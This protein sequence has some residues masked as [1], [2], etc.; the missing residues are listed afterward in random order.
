MRCLNFLLSK[1]DYP[2]LD[3][4]DKAEKIDSRKSEVS[5]RKTVPQ[6][7]A[8][9]SKN[10]AILFNSGQASARTQPNRPGPIG[11]AAQIPTQV[12]THSDGKHAPID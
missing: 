7:R 2:G 4:N 3:Q 1:G 10:S 8:R 12:H 6:A 11:Q 9:L 5:S